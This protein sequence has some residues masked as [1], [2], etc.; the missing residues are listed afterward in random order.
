VILNF[1]VQ[2]AEQKTE[3]LEKKHKKL[4]VRRMKSMSYHHPLSISPRCDKRTGG[5]ACSSKAVWD[6]PIKSD[7]L[8]SKQQ[9]KEPEAARKRKNLKLHGQVNR[10]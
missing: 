6:V 9:Q 3:L 5:M 10:P 8:T 1:V 7:L 2:V 4:E